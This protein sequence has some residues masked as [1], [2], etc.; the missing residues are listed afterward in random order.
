MK[1]YTL[2]QIFIT[3]IIYAVL[4]WCLEVTFHLFKSKKF[5]NRGFL[6]GPLCPIY[7]VGAV[8]VLMFLGHLENNFWSI[9]IGGAV[10]ASLL[11][12]VTGYALE[13][14]FNTRWWDYSKKK[15]NI[16]GYISLD[17]S[18]LWGFVSVFMMDLLQPRVNRMVTSIPSNL[19]DPIA[20]F[21]FG[22]FMLDLVTT[23]R[24]LVSLR[25]V[26]NEI[27]EAKEEWNYKINIIK[28]NLEDRWDS[29][30]E[31]WDEKLEFIKSEAE[32]EWEDEDGDS[33]LERFSKIAN[34]L[35]KRQK[36]FFDK[37]PT[38]IS[39]E[40]KSKLKNLIDR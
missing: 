9:F 29:Q 1:G 20:L 35:E 21:I 31:T 39:E 26:L 3:F 30:L 32:S 11:E 16:G 15:F 4:G 5:I 37:Y 17:F 22:I 25:A 13:K 40:T 38:L 6:H 27:N 28:D 19:V 33:L 36:A 23:V 7:G 34:G 8:M 14:I 12:L 24:T 18:I 2:A 10:F